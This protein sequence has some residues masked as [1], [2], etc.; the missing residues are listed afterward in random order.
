MKFVSN[1]SLNLFIK[2]IG[3][4]LS[5]PFILQPLWNRPGNVAS[6]NNI[7]GFFESTCLKIS[8]RIRIKGVIADSGYYL[9]KFI[10]VLMDGNRLVKF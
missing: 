3:A 1:K 5:A 2:N 4:S 6:W 7:V 8:E 10:E 9:L